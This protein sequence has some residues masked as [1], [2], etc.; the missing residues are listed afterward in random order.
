MYRKL[1]RTEREN[2][3][4]TDGSLA[5]FQHSH[6]ARVERGAETV[7]LLPVCLKILKL[8]NLK[9]LPPH[10]LYLFVSPPGVVHVLVLVHACLLDLS[11]HPIRGAYRRF[12]LKR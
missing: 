11:T 9:T 1:M 2:D 12:G 5:Q 10:H 6:R 4:R 3:A 7:L 8:S